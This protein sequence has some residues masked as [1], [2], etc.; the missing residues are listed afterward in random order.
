MPI[1]NTNEDFLR[2]AI[3][4]I[5]NQ[6]YTDFE[7]LILNDSPDNIKLDEIV[8]SYKDSRIKYLKNEKN[9]GITPSRNKLL[10]IAQ[11][12]YLAVMDHDDISLPERFQKQVDFLDNNPDYGVVSCHYYIN[13]RR[14][15]SKI[16]INRPP[17]ADKDIKL[18]LI[19]YCVVLHPA[20]ML[21]KSVL[22]DN[23][24]NYE[25]EFSPAEDYAL[26]CKLIAYTKF[27]NLSEV[28]FRYR[29]HSSNTSKKILDKMHK[30]DYLIKENNRINYPDLYEEYLLKSTR[31][32]KYNLFEF[33]P[34]FSITKKRDITIFKLFDLIP[35]LSYKT[36]FYFR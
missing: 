28:L 3:E 25:L 5:L 26:W 36:K 23:N 11:G 30:S 17:Q 2:A 16:K 6:T 21:R 14:N 33:I 7:F 8:A 13:D 32:T 29:K 20:S 27:F 10:E 15:P 34:I 4:S 35:I 24:I 12:E 22:I 19:K 18:Q 31:K 1:Y 9:I